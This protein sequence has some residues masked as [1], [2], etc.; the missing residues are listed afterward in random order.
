MEIEKAP[1]AVAQDVGTHALVADGELVALTARVEIATLQGRVGC[2]V[3]GTCTDGLNALDLQA[4]EEGAVGCLVALRFRRD[5][6]ELFD[7]LNNTPL[8]VEFVVEE[9]ASVRLEF[10]CD[11]KVSRLDCSWAYQRPLVTPRYLG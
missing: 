10:R 5:R 11:S 4:A 2:K 6:E 3:G 7:S 8:R 1:A 9:H